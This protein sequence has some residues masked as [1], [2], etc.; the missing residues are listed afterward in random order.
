MILLMELYNISDICSIPKVSGNNVEI[1]ALS[2]MYNRPI[3]I[4][5]YSPEHINIFHGNYNTDTPPIRLSYHHGNHYNS[6]VD[7]RRLTIGAGLGFSSLQGSNFDK[8]Q[9]KAA[10]RAQQDQ[11]VDNA[12][13]AEA[14]FYSD[15]ELTEKEIE[16]M[17]MEASRAEYVA[18]NER[19]KHQ[20]G[21]TESS[22]SSSGPSSSGANSRK[23]QDKGAVNGVQ[24]R[25]GD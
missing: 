18:A 23:E 21:P 11:Q 10:I 13:L 1:Q 16:C 22:S 20:L 19:F 3:H 25:A 6:L 17:V 9:V 14:R 5:S 2:E 4:Y 8:N 15:V 24:L 7:P 12:L